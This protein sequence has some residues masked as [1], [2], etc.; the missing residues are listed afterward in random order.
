MC[1]DHPVALYMNPLC[2]QVQ[3]EI[4]LCFV[5]CL[6]CQQVQRYS[7]SVGLKAT[8]VVFAMNMHMCSDN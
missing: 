6:C 5:L 4:T 7:I 8:F 1:H 2:L 3:Q